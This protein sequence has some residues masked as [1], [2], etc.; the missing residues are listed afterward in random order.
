MK[1]FV[2]ALLLA[3]GLAACASSPGTPAQGGDGGGEWSYAK[4]PH[5]EN[6]L[7]YKYS[8]YSLNGDLNEGIAMSC[9]TVTP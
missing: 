2:A 1:K 3:F 8:N 4:G 7:F 6:C 9:D 5:G